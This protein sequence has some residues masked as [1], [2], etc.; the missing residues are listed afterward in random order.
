MT[1]WLYKDLKSLIV[2]NNAK[3]AQSVTHK[4]VTQEVLES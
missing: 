2:A 1:A 4:S 3:L